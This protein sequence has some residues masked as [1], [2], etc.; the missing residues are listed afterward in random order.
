MERIH[1][2]LAIQDG[3]PPARMLEVLGA[4]PG[5]AARNTA[6]LTRCLADPSADVR[7][8][9]VVALA[10]LREA[11]LDTILAVFAC[12]QDAEP[13]VVWHCGFALAANCEAWVGTLVRATASVRGGR[14]L[15]V[16]RA[17]QYYAGRSALA[18]ERFA[19][20]AE[21]PDEQVRE[22]VRQGHLG[23]FPQRDR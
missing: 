19:A 14:L 9:A 22:V 4:V 8:A 10:E 5:F 16:L 12:L 13:R 1:E 6:V 11:S 17:L 20:L 23:P 18:R 21:H 15:E 2:L 7:H 3:A